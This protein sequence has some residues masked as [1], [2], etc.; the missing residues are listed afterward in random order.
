MERSRRQLN[1]FFNREKSASYNS[2]NLMFTGDKR[3]DVAHGRNIIC[4]KM[5]N[6]T[7][8]TKQTKQDRSTAKVEHVNRQN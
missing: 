5:S 8:T 6:E 1:N 4:Q 2:T 7:Q 3:C